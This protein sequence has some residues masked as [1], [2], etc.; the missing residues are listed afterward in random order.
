MRTCLLQ[1]LFRNSKLLDS[2]MGP[3]TDSDI[4]DQD[5]YSD[6]SNIEPFKRL[7]LGVSFQAPRDIANRDNAKISPPIYE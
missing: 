1:H 6:N 5:K 7:E 4:V 2:G 3:D